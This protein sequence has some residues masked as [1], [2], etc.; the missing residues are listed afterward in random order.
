M[1]VATTLDVLRE[2]MAAIREND[3][4]R[5]RELLHEA[6]LQDP[7]SETAWLWLANV[8]ETPLE[9][10]VALEKVTT[11]N[12]HNEKA[13]AAL[14]EIR[15]PAGIAAAKAQDVVT[16]RRLLRAVVGD[17]P[18]CEQGW[19]WLASATE[20]P[21]DALSHLQKVLA[22]NPNN[23]AAHKGVDY[24]QGKIAKLSGVVTNPQRSA[25]IQ[26]P[27][28]RTP[29]ADPFDS[30]SQSSGRFGMP[31][32]EL[33]TLIVLAIDVSR[34]N[35]KLIGLTLAAEGFQLVEA[36]DAMEAADRIREDGA[37]DLI[38]LDGVNP[39]METSEFCQILRENPSTSEVPLILLGGKE[40]L[41][42]QVRAASCGINLFLPKP[43]QPES[44]VR[45]ARHLVRSQSSIVG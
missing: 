19:F 32:R 38:V 30:P 39:S 5:T 1:S 23:S 14:R 21:H 13:R 40:G 42:E 8:A 24:F 12:P 17:D 35:R 20:S 22:L 31:T 10:A 11:L 28:T 34:I 4:P 3:L 43:L 16:A 2:A 41:I 6:T 26:N 45:A 9:A 25:V 29:V 44:L 36:S 7:R 27:T 37:P 15:L 18:N 33:P